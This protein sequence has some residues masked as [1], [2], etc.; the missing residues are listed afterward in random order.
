MQKQDQKKPR[1]TKILKQK[2]IINWQ[3]K[4]KVLNT[5]ENNFL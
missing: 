1:K 5:K 2:S 3:A 4:D